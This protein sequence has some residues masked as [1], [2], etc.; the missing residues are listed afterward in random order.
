MRPKTPPIASQ[1]PVIPAVARRLKVCRTV[2]RLMPSGD[3][4]FLIFFRLYMKKLLDTQ[5]EVL[6]SSHSFEGRGRKSSCL[7][8]ASSRSG[9]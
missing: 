3:S 2:R 8:T 4:L 9:A 5:G 1:P 6:L 7:H